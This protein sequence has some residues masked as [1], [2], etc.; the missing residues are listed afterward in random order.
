MP[1][2]L[3]IGNLSALSGTL[4]FMLFNL[5]RDLGSSSLTFMKI[6][7]RLP[8]VSLCIHSICNELFTSKSKH[9]P[10]VNFIISFIFIIV[11]VMLKLND[12]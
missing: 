5:S 10:L 2:L 4:L 9:L 3:I 12:T 8:L 6:P 1:P 7:I 11:C